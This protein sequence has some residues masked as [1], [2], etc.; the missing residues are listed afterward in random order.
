[1]KTETILNTLILS[2]S[3]STVL[4]TLISY[5]IY[6]MKQ[7]PKHNVEN[8]EATKI[9]GTFFRRH[10]PGILPDLP[11][12]E[13][14]STPSKFAKYNTLPNY[15]GILA[16]IIFFSLAF[17]D[18]FVNVIDKW[19]R[20]SQIERIHALKDKHMLELYEFD[21]GKRSHV[22]KEFIPENT[23]H[24]LYQKI[25]QLKKNKIV[26][27]SWPHGSGNNLQHLNASVEGWKSFLRRSN[28]N[29]SVSESSDVSDGDI[30]I[31]PHANTLSEDQEKFLDELIAQNKSLL[32]TGACDVFDVSGEKSKTNWCEQ[33]LQ[34]TFTSKKPDELSKPTIFA[35]RRN[36]GWLLP[37][38]LILPWSPE[39]E[40]YVVTSSL[41]NEASAFESTFKGKIPS[42]DNKFPIRALFQKKN[43][44][45]LGWMALEPHGIAGKAEADVFYG[46]AS[47]VE[48][49]SWLGKGLHIEVAP[50][51]S[52]SS[53]GMVVSV[54][55]ESYIE[56]AYEIWEILEKTSTPA[57]FFVVAD[58]M[59]NDDR[60]TKIS[61]PLL[62]FGS[63]SLDHSI[64]T[65][66][67]LESQF[68]NIQDSRLYLEEKFS[69]P[70][71][72]FH[73]PEEKFNE[74][75]INAVL[76]N[77][78]NYFVGDQRFSRMAPLFLGQNFVYFPRILTDDILIKRDRSLIS[79]ED[80]LKVLNDD[81]KFA[82]FLGGMYYLNVHS[83]VFG[84]GFYL[85]VLKK[86][87]EQ[88]HDNLWKTTFG[89]LT[90]RYR[91]YNQV[92][93][94]IKD[95]S[96][97]VTNKSSKAISDFVFYVNG[98]KNLIKDF[99]PKKAMT[100]VP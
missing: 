81:Q 41:Q 83:Q 31:I 62:D 48:S 40:S 57:T 11:S 55:S 42:E 75:T 70:I 87:F 67:K 39:D 93:F 85:E 66:K 33:K 18:V 26:I 14:Q 53:S 74:D 89:E 21:A 2:L 59:K 15:F 95:T 76:Q 38:G 91:A 10:I 28:I 30:Y 49:L 68:N 78:M 7:F 90:S 1:M 29:F 82:S 61:S 6:K 23:K 45:K 35:S 99:P 13:V 36:P 86:F 73:P 97:I 20:S 77:R 52:G 46:E 88:P 98:E 34:L 3:V 8:K 80:V 25:D 65:T 63:H 79:D 50:W 92:E 43:N 44:T 22:L 32:F 51:K 100:I 71:H 19:K 17:K 96:V 9:E 47:L 24:F 54:D 12:E 37:P 27:L 64:M 5:L 56:G 84:R 72:G 58:E 94:Q 60:L 4:I 69:V 16:A